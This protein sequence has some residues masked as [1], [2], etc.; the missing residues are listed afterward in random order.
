M[1]TVAFLIAHLGGGGAERVTVSVANY[2][3]NH[4]Y[5]VHLIIFSDKY[6]EY[7]V[8]KKIKKYYLD[9]SDKKLFDVIKK[10]HS[11][12]NILDRIHPEYVCSLGFSYRFL[13]VGG[14]MSKYNFVLSERNDPRQMYTNK[15]DMEIVKY[16][17]RRAKHVVFQTKDAQN[18]FSKKIQEH[19]VVIPNPIKEDLI[20]AYHGKRE[21][22][23]VAYSRLNY[24]KNIPMML[25]AFKKFVSDHSEY[26][27]EI[28]G[29]GEAEEELKHYTSE[30]GINDKVV[31][32][33]FQKNVHEKIS[34][35]MCF[36]STSDFEGISN[37]MLE[38][39]AI[40]LPCICTD[41]PVGGAA[42]FIHHGKN[43]FLTRVGNEDDV[44]KYL[45]E[46]ADSEELVNNMSIEAGKIRIELTMDRICGQWMELM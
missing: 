41:C 12:R 1:K 4:D 7:T 23:V 35:A 15:I 43:G 6:N 19:S 2:F 46:M 44:V 38:S 33:G 26:V 18:F 3:C 27:L 29:R 32:C 5:D 11:L 28:Y 20:P 17:L 36:L 9:K 16:C 37:S 39:L 31:F 30:L 42:M 24:Q 8:D 45:C 40:G 10:V 22:R 25:R 14:L 13:F 21:K 34:T